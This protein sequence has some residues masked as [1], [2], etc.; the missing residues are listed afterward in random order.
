MD[1]WARWAGSDR[2]GWGGICVIVSGPT[3]PPE[4][5]EK[6]Y[7]DNNN[8]EHFPAHPTISHFHRLPT[9]RSI[10]RLIKP[11]LRP[12]KEE[13]I[14]RNER[15]ATRRTVRMMGTKPERGASSEQVFHLSLFYLVEFF[16][17]VLGQGARF[18][19]GWR[20]WMDEW[21]DGQRGIIPRG[22]R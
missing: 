17:L 3:E 6:A 22:L 1:G 15:S 2:I 9:D 18:S 11:R 13:E 19:R 21:M 5:T 12:G 8:L 7:Y 20:R 4:P 16:F 14:A 10:D